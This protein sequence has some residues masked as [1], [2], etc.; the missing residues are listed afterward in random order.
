MSFVVTISLSRRTV[1][2][3]LVVVLQGRDRL[4]QIALVLQVLPPILGEVHE[5]HKTDL[6]GKQNVECSQALL[7]HKLICVQAG[8]DVVESQKYAASSS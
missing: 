6:N 4:G 3:L 5:C 2:W 8:V 1:A 7:M